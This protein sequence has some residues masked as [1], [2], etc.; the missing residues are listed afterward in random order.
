MSGAYK[1]TGLDPNE[2]I[3]YGSEEAR[4]AWDPNYKARPQNADFSALSAE[5]IHAQGKHD[6]SQKTAAQAYEVLM[7]EVNELAAALLTGD[8]RQIKAEVLQVQ[9]V[10][11]RIAKQ[12]G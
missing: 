3:E 2:R 1:A 10:A 6:W 7:C 5:L 9:C 11:E 12:F 8:N 4:K